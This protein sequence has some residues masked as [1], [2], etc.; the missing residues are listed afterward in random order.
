MARI[1]I[2]TATFGPGPMAETIASV[3]SQVFDGTVDYEISYHNP[4]PGDRNMKNVVAQ[5]QRA[6]QM[7]LD[8]GYDAVLTVEHDMQIPSSALQTMWDM[9]ESVVYAPYMLRHKTNVI[10]LW[11][12]E[13]KKNLG[14]SLTFYP[15]EL[16]RYRRAG[17]GPVSGV[18]WGCTLIKSSVLQNVTIHDADNGAGDIPFSHDVLRM[19]IIPIGA[20]SV[21]CLHYHEGEWL[22]PYANGGGNAVRVYCNQTINANIDG[23]SKRLVQGSYYTIPKT[24]AG[25]LQRAGYITVTL[26][27]ITEPEQTY[28]PVIETAVSPVTKSRSKRATS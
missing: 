7:T 9:N 17:R 24:V 20:F 11:R 22:E 5:Y 27:E 12:Y 15:D 6:R 23:E 14:S 21:E 18:G 13:N 4:Y 26:G 8:G 3:Q 28:S 25:D 1:L 2:Y 16:R 10:S 19:G